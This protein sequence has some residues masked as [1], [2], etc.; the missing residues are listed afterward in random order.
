MEWSFNRKRMLSVIETNENPKITYY[1]CCCIPKRKNKY[2]TNR[3]GAL[4]DTL[5][6]NTTNSPIH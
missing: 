6:Q 5:I 3:D 4:V 1:V 2:K